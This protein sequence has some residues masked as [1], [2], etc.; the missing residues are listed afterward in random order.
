[1]KKIILALSVVASI[2]AMAQDSV[3]IM[4]TDFTN[5]VAARD[6]R[7]QTDPPALPV[8]ETYLPPEALTMATGKYGKGLYSVKQLRIGNGDSAYQV[9]LIEDSVTRLEWIGVDGSVVTD[10]WRTD[11]GT[12]STGTPM[13]P[14]QNMNINNNVVT[15]DTTSTTVD[16]TMTTVDTTMNNMNN[17]VIA[18]TTATM[19]TTTV[20]DSSSLGV[21]YRKGNHNL[22]GYRN[23]IWIETT[24]MKDTDD[25]YYIRRR[26]A[27]S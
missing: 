15:T 3:R 19:D 10:M 2:T 11:T 9:I 4:N 16:T 22:A 5:R 27:R 25:A 17:P 8:I 12:M 26:A 24:G 1:M 7:G 14:T 6:M 21:K 20:R 18:D 23:R 13:A